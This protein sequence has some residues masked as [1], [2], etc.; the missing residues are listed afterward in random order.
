MLAKIL[1]SS[2]FDII[3]I[4]IQTLLQ[5]QNLKKDHVD[6]LYLE[7]GEKLGVE[8]SRKIKNFLSTK[9]YQAKGKAVILEDGRTL[10]PEAQNSLLKSLEEL[11]KETLFLI[12]TSSENSFLPTIL[13]RCELIY[14]HPRGVGIKLAKKT[15]DIEKLI[16]CSLEERF[17]YIEN[18]KE[19]TA[20]LKDLIGYFHQNLASHM[21]SGNTK[22]I[23][24]LTELLEAEKWANSN[25]NTRAILEYLMLIM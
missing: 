8:Q 1:I 21:S 23:H 11:P 13:S 18:C 16:N 15:D 5:Q 6:V 24:F 3:Q 4:Q 2:D 12:G 17:A 19:K 7:K 9:P 20:L 25:V 22:S 10:T 14:L